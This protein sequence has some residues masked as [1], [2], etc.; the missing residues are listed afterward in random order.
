MDKLSDNDFRAP[1]LPE[2]L[3]AYRFRASYRG[4]EAA[5]PEDDP[6]PAWLIRLRT[7]GALHVG[8]M[9]FCDAKFF[10]DKKIA[11]QCLMA[12]RIG[13]HLWNKLGIRGPALVS[14]HLRTTTSLLPMERQHY[15][16]RLQNPVSTL[17]LQFFVPYPDGLDDGSA[18]AI[19]VLHRIAQAA[20][21][22]RSRLVAED[23][24]LLPADRWGRG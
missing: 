15:P 13:R 18:L 2:S 3:S 17:N 16:E 24:T 21:V 14:V 9:D 1:D 23:G 8:A 22:Q 20:G 11:N 19:V 5:I 6:R 12:V 10:L 7:D 4:F